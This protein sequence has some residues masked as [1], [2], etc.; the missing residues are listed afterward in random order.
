MNTQVVGKPLGIQNLPV[1][2]R[3]F[4]KSAFEPS[5]QNPPFYL[6]ANCLCA[7]ITQPTNVTHFDIL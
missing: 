2:V 1:N 7:I 4:A 6:T 3:S 5:V